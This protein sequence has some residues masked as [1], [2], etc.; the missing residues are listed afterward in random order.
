MKLK[1][2]ALGFIKS[3]GYNSIKCLFRNRNNKSMSIF[4]ILIIHT[5]EYIFFKGAE[6]P[7]FHRNLNQ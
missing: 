6:D 5:S 3:L 1:H 2:A 4:T 7:K